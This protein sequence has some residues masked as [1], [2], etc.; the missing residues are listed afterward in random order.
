MRQWVVPSRPADA[1]RFAP[2]VGRTGALEV[3]HTVRTE[4]WLHPDLSLCLASAGR[5][6]PA[7]TGSPP[8][9]ST[10]LSTGRGWR[11]EGHGLFVAAAEAME[12]YS[13]GLYDPDEL[14]VAPATELGRAVMDAEGM[15]RFSATERARSAAY[16]SEFE[17]GRRI[18]WQPGV[19][20]HTGRPAHLPAVMT[21]LTAEILD[22]E[23]FWLPFSTGVAVHSTVEAALANAIFELVEREATALWWL[24]RLPLP[25]LHPAVLTA[26]TI[27]LVGWLTDR[28]IRTQFFDATTDLGLPTVLCLQ[29]ADHAD[30]VAQAVGTAAAADPT[31]AAWHA[32]V[33]CVTA[34]PLLHGR[35]APRRRAD[36]LDVADGA[37]HLSRPAR[38]RAFAFLTDGAA[39]RPARR[40]G[41]VRGDLDA[42]LGVLHAHHLPAY[43][44]DLTTR[45]AALAGLVAVRVVVPRMV[46]MSVLPVAQYRGTPRLYQAPAAMGHRTRPESRLNR[47][48]LPVT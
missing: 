36:Y 29:L 2:L 4:G 20:L 3:L 7:P 46:P 16:L 8:G 19:D 31:D 28:G 15:A 45:E 18:R 47:Y 32:L 6:R 33:E 37:T 25:R 43:A 24:H 30:L 23:R 26:A 39:D 1:G 40:P 35:T 38:R 48:P 34:R 41:P 9:A 10:P 5:P 14:L 12:R 27:E 17:P 21:L 42:L 22:A 13:A 44:T 11:D